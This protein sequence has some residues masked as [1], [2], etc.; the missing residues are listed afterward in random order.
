MLVYIISQISLHAAHIIRWHW[1]TTH[2]FS[3][4]LSSLILLSHLSI[5]SLNLIKFNLHSVDFIILQPLLIL[6][7]LDFTPTHIDCTLH[8]GSLDPEI[9]RR[10][11]LSQHVTHLLFNMISLLQLDLEFVTFQE[12]S[13][14]LLNERHI[15]LQYSLIGITVLLGVFLELVLQ[16]LYTVLQ[17][18]SLV[19]IL[20]ERILL[21]SW[22]LFLLQNPSP[23]Q[24]Y[25]TFLE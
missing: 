4:H 10:A 6:K 2:N 8:S 11:I 9:R 23:I 25:H 21:A 5:L 1:L 3:L 17:L 19:C 16:R 15:L 14:D 18:S 7:S 24:P 22:E 20:A 12:Q 13:V